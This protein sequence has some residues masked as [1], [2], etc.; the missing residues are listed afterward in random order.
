MNQILKQRQNKILIVLMILGLSL[1]YFLYSIAADEDGTVAS[2]VT[3]L[4]N[5][6]NDKQRQLLEIKNRINTLQI[7]INDQRSKIASLNNE[8]HL[9]DLQ[10]QQAEEQIKAADAEMEFI[11]LDITVTLNQIAEAE[12]EIAE[13]KALLIKL[14]RDMYNQDQASALEI[15]LTNNN[16]SDFLNVVQNT[17]TF[18][19]RSQELLDDLKSL[20][21]ELDAKN[22][23]L[24][25]RKLELETVKLQAE[26]TQR[27][28]LAQQ[29]QRQSILSYTRGQ[30]SRYQEL[31]ENVSEEEA[32]I[33]REIFNL[34]LNIR[35]QLGDK[36]IPTVT[37]GFVWPMDGILTQA[38]GNTGFTRLGYSFHNGLDIAAPPNTPVRSAGDGVVYATGSGQ[39]AYGNW[40]VIRH[41]LETDGNGLKNLFTLY[42]HLNKILVSPGQGVLGG[43]TIGL[44]GNTG[45]TTRLLYGP[46]RGYHLHFSVF[47]EEGFGIKD[48]AYPE[49]Y[50]PYQIPYGYTYNPMDFLK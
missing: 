21:L 5:Q 47:D 41:T 2:A 25:K 8:I 14:I 37:N 7:N 49:V 40:V 24:A 30:E 43:D 6:K 33:Q 42:A 12:V 20:K 48:G 15:I 44:Q 26:E 31:L 22:E 45:N 32:Q 17:L 11:N 50:G 13:K 34:D 18:Q 1:S 39:T 36:S 29:T 4:E 38:Y 19:N 28:L 46:E 23:Q 10:I 9:Y 35:Q 27:T 16:F 3:E